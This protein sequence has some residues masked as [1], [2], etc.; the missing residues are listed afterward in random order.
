MAIALLDITY[1]IK[2]SYENPECEQSSRQNTHLIYIRELMQEGIPR[3]V[4]HMRKPSSQRFLL[5]MN[6]RIH[7][8][9]KPSEGND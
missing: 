1:T 4:M 3:N 7:N 8:Q 6:H 9:M 5:I 2:K